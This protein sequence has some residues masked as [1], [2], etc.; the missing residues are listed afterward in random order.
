ME[1]KIFGIKVYI[2]I[3]FIGLIALIML[4]DRSG[5]SLYGFIAMFIHEMGHL[6]LMAAFKT[7][8]SKIVFQPAGIIITKRFT[9]NTFEKDLAI[10]TGGCLAN[11]I[12]IIISTIIYFFGG[13]DP[14]WF[15]FAVVNASICLFNLIPIHGLD[16]LDIIKFSLY[17]KTDKAKADKICKIVSLLSLLIMIIGV[18]LLIFY[19]KENYTLLICVL[20]LVILGLMNL[21]S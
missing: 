2:S 19:T 12:V 8:P 6:L 15:A 18:S 16:G 10:A 7:M 9:T 13:E 14:V 3:F 20:Y 21:K 5:L 4:L 11:L 1:F 17:C